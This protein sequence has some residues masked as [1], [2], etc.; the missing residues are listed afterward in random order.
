MSEERLRFECTQCGRC[1]TNQGEYAHVYVSDEECRAIARFL[2]LRL[3]AFKRRYTFVDA[4]GW[5]QL[6]FSGESCLFLEPET[7]GCR[8]YP[9]RPTQCRTFPFWRNFV[10]DGEWT[11]EVRELCEGVGQGRSHSEDEAEAHMR[12]MDESDSS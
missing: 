4:E 8:I 3:P 6:T 7:K 9:V 12:A 11:A 2:E 10:R 1:C 5:R